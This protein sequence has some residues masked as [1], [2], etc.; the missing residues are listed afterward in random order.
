M[1][2]ASLTLEQYQKKIQAWREELAHHTCLGKGKC[3]CVVLSIKID[4]LEMEV[5]KLAPFPKRTDATEI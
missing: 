1:Q 2:K 4:L 5:T 3:F